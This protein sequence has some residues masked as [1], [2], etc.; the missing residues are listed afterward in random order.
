MLYLRIGFYAFRESI[1]LDG[2]VEF[3]GLFCEYSA[4]GFCMGVAEICS[5][6]DSRGMVRNFEHLHYAFYGA[7]F[8]L[9]FIYRLSISFILIYDKLI[10]LA[11]PPVVVTV[12]LHP[13]L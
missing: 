4:F 3:E 1:P 12:Y 7:L 5:N 8:V 10:A 9:P 2:Y 13:S 6:I 11:I